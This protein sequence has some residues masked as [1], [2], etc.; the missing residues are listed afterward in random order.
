ME[1]LHKLFGHRWLTPKA[2]PGKSIVDNYG[3][4]ASQDIKKGEIIRI[5]GGLVLQKK[6]LKK[7]HKLIHGNFEMQISD[8]FFLAPATPEEVGTETGLFNHGCDPNIGFLDAVTLIAIKDI[9]AGVEL[10]IDYG[11]ALSFFEPFK[12]KCGS[13]NC[14]KI[15][16]PDDWK[17]PELQKK[18]GEYFSPYLK[19]KFSAL[20]YT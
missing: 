11:F 12:C 4:I 13:A 7:Y 17:N 15:I 20:P 9:V 19:R 3:T 16:K 2:R 5:T 18:Y 6:D 14:R 8:N 1:D 10:L